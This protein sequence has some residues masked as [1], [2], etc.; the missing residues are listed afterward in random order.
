MVSL[1][2]QGMSHAHCGLASVT[3]SVL[4]GCCCLV[5][6]APTARRSMFECTK[7]D[8]A[9]A[10]TKEPGVFT[11]H[12]RS[13]HVATQTCY[14]HYHRT[15]TFEPV[16]VVSSACIHITHVHA[17]PGASLDHQ[18]ATALWDS[19]S[20]LATRPPCSATAHISTHIAPQY[21]S[22]T[23]FGCMFLCRLNGRSTDQDALADKLTLATSHTHTRTHTRT[24]MNTGTVGNVQHM[25]RHKHMWRA[26][27]AAAAASAFQQVHCRGVLMGIE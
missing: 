25:S 1:L 4:F 7:A 10:G 17:L 14:E 5:A 15:R 24:H 6:V 8:T 21:N 27:H 13:I 3:N 2:Y 9:Y 23:P 26:W 22:H 12:T 19:N 11:Q 16:A 18:N 20:V